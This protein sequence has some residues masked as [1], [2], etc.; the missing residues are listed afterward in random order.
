VA[1]FTTPSTDPP[2]PHQ[3][4]NADCFTGNTDPAGLTSDPPGVQSDPLLACGKPSPGNPD[5]ALVVRACCPGGR[6]SAAGAGP[7]SATRGGFTLDRP[8]PAGNVS[9]SVA[10]ALTGRG[11]AAGPS[12]SLPS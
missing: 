2:P 10:A 5:P 6:T 8:P 3:V 4:Y 1:L 9:V 11:G 7:S 12:R